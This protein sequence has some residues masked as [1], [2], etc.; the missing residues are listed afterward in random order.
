MSRLRALV[1]LAAGVAEA[2]AAEDRLADA[3]ATDLSDS[4][5]G[6]VSVWLRPAGGG[7]LRLEVG[8]HSSELLRWTSSLVQNA[9]GT[10]HPSLAAGEP[11]VIWGDEYPGGTI[12]GALYVLPMLARG[13]LVGAVA[14]TARPGQPMIDHDT[15]DFAVS[16]ADM[17][18]AT[19]VN[20][21]VLADAT[22]MNEHLRGQ[23]RILDA[24]SDAVIGL[25]AE[26]RVIAWNAGAQRL[27]GYSRA[28]VVG[29][30]LF[31]LLSTQFFSIESESLAVADVCAAAAGSGGWQGEAHERSADGL[32]LTVLCSLDP[33]SDSIGLPQGFVLVNRDVTERRREE[34]R[35]LR[36]ALTGLPNRRMLTNRLYDAFARA[37]RRGTSLAVLVVDLQQFRMMNDV[38]GRSAGDEILRTTGRRLAGAVR[39]SDTVGRLEG[40]AFAVVLENVGGDD[41]VQM[42]ADRI[43]RA[44]IEPVQAGDDVIAVRPTIGA[45]LVKGAEGLN[46]SPE[47]LIE[48]AND[49]RHMAKAAGGTFALEHVTSTAA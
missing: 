34:D 28:E 39:S 2:M 18:A 15:L 46:V 25:D 13:R 33:T 6:A 48:L 35:A 36:D 32:P 49:A 42:A 31:D 29:R 40:D 47:G 14:A 43:E 4:F 12:D 19:L 10:P 3:L 17:A 20:A 9:S 41:T 44:L 11:V 16:L 1:D 30:D 23:A 8:Q 21:R 38:Y 26:R 27:Y 24:I 7:P 37:C 22:A 45:I 5:A